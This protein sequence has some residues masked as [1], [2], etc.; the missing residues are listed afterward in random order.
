[1]EIRQA[2]TIAKALSDPHR[3][4]ALLALRNGEL[5]VC[6]IIE[7]LG[8]SPSSVSRHMSM[9]KSAGLLESRKDS[10]WV[11]YRFAGVQKDNDETIRLLASLSDVLEN[12]ADVRSDDTRLPEITGRLAAALCNKPER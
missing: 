2:V 5:C 9:L 6:Q 11:Y 4:R 3:V 8:L 7:L 12:A 1:M 10:R